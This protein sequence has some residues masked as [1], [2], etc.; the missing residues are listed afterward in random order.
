PSSNDDSENCSM[1]NETLC[2]SP[3]RSV[4]RRSSSLAL[5]FLANSSTALGS[6][7][8]SAIVEFTPPLEANATL[9]E[10]EIECFYDPINSVYPGQN[11][12]VF[13]SLHDEKKGLTARGEILYITSRL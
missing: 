8:V 9:E 11:G 12:R 2:H 4:K 7:L 3:G 5:F 6:A 10:T 1:G 13:S